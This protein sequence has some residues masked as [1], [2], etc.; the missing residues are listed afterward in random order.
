MSRLICILFFLSPYFLF[1]QN[2]K[3][4]L[5]IGNSYTYVND[6][7]TMLQQLALTMGDSINKD[8]YTMGGYTLQMHAT[9]PSCL[10]KINS[11][12]WN[13]VIIQAQSQEP[14]FDPDT[15]AVYTYP[16]AQTLVNQVKANDSCSQVLFYMTWGRKNGDAMNCAS[17]PIVCTYE[18]MQ[19]RLRQSYIEM[20]TNNNA[21]VSPVGVSWRTIRQTDTT[22]ELYQTDES[23]PSISGT[24]VAA[25]TFYS[26]IFQKPISSTFVPIGVDTIQAATIK[27]ISSD[28]VLD[29]LT[30]W[31]IDTT[32]AP[33]I[34]SGLIEP[35]LQNH[36]SIF[37]NPFS[38][39][40]N[41][42]EEFSGQI[43][44]T[45]IFGRIK[46]EK[47]VEKQN[48]IELTN[49]ASGIYFISLISTN[50]SRTYE[51]IRF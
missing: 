30:T 13:Y 2:I 16:Y 34:L 3:K 47:I 45:D 7:P 33:C 8:S 38:S 35:N 36:I 41:F 4:V 20:A 14:S 19:Y 6:L 27:Q 39:T 18:G 51:V 12:K 31:K 25:C 40:I 9:D 22:I 15:V 37:P 11:Q 28:I 5:F 49:L 21:Q 32:I 10:A 48:S 43:V 1:G 42:S 50:V 29:S 44:I 23:H 26:A 46:F 24:F 17:Y